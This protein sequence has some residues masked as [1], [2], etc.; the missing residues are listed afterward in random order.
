MPETLNRGAGGTEIGGTNFWGSVQVGRWGGQVAPFSLSQKRVVFWH[1]AH[2]HNGFRIGSNIATPLDD[3]LG[4]LRQT[5]ASHLGR[6][7][8]RIEHLTRPRYEGR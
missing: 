7:E 5:L 8:Q 3:L 1:N 2:R 6:G 4:H